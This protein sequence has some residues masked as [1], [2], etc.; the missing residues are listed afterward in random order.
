MLLAAEVT[1][2]AGRT[3]KHRQLYNTIK[4]KSAPVFLACSQFPTA[5]FPHTRM[6]EEKIQNLVLNFK[7]CE[8]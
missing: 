2:V 6:L 8:V 3:E 5:E 4:G 1:A 7:H